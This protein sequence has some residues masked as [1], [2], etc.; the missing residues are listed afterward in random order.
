MDWDAALD[1]F[2]AYLT[3]ELARSP[4]T[5]D[6]YV[7]DV[8]AFR[9]TIAA[10]RGGERAPTRLD[11]LDV[12]AHLATLF[13]RNDAASIGR[14]LSSL[15]AFF[16]FLEKRGAITGNPARAV[17]GPKRRRPLPRALDV[18]GAFAL[19]EAPSTTGRTSHRRLSADE[20]ARAGALRLRDRAL[21]EV[22]YG[23]G[24]RV[25]EAVGLDLDDLDADRYGTLVVHVRRGKGNKSRIVPLG[26]KA[27]EALAAWR[28]ARG[29]L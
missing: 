16:R 25:S 24:L 22:L 11:A 3:V 27:T 20:E 15:R 23:A 6:A 12:R 8:T 2:T 13:G 29:A 4:R 14:K 10:G 9:A 21:L 17:R 28:A 5:V 18:D 7:R 26:A 1:A 19:V